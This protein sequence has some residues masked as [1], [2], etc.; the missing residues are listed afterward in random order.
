LVSKKSYAKV[1]IFLKI[2]GTRDKY[3][4]LVSRFIR[5]K[6]LY[7]IIEFVPSDC[8][9]FTIDGSFSCDTKSNLIYKAYNLLLQYTKSPKLE[10][11]FK[12]HKVVVKKNIPE[13]S[14]LGGGSS[15]G[16]TFM[17]M[18]NDTLHLGL[19]KNTLSLL[20]SKIGAD[21]PFFIYEYDSANVS[22]I[23]ENIKQYKEEQLTLE[24]VT[25]KIECNSAKIYSIYR[26][27]FYSPA[28]KNLV[29]KLQNLTSNEILNNYKIE[30]LNDLYKSALYL[31]PDL[32]KWAKDGWFFSGSGSSFF[33]IKD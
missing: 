31:E 24:I 19:D 25:P 12:T 15:N 16:A 2:V 28:D 4:E 3:H 5:V 30:F 21:L 8:K 20:S 29:S 22:G 9:D 1:N 18:C 14:G 17:L 13:Q 6:D 10:N 27:H 32:A 11:Y 23:G 7:D 26:E 33:K